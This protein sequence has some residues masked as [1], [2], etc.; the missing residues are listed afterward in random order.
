MLRLCLVE[1]CYIAS[2]RQA[3]Q[4]LRVAWCSR[5]ISVRSMLHA[6]FFVIKQNSPGA[7]SMIGGQHTVTAGGIPAGTTEAEIEREFTKFGTLSSV[8]VARKPPG[9]GESF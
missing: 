1:A 8:W 7:A 3:P 2:R 5:C 9:F 6:G 4:Q